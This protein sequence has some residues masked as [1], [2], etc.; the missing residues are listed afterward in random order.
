[1]S[2]NDNAIVYSLPWAGPSDILEYFKPHFHK[3]RAAYYRKDDTLKVQG[4]VVDKLIFLVN[5]IVKIST[6]NEEGEEK[7]YWYGAAP[8]PVALAPYFNGQELTASLTAY[9]DCEVVLFD[10]EVFSDMI[11]SDSALSLRL[12]HSLA[13][14]VQSLF[15]HI[16]HM[17][18]QSPQKSICR[19]IYTYAMHVNANND[20]TQKHSTDIVLNMTQKEIASITSAHRVTVA[21]IL[22]ALKKDNVLE[23][24]RSGHVIIH[25]LDTLRKLCM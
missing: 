22:S 10:K 14:K 6:L 9:T 25:D 12:I 20:I 4:M 24:D 13:S 15:D 5:G 18:F 23:L 8:A 21:R 19:F 2:N 1:M 17:T 7:I 16:E 3:G 11:I